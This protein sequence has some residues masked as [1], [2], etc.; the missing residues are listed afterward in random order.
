MKNKP[1]TNTHISTTTQIDAKA[2]SIKLGIDVHADSYRVV[3]QVDHATPQPAQKFSPEGF[4]VWAKRQMGLAEEVHSCYEAGPFGYGLHRALE[5][6]GIHNVVIRP[7]NWDELGKAV[8][9]DKTD[10]LALVQRLDRYVQGN[11]KALAVVCVPTPE[12]EMA[13]SQSRQREQLL[14]HRLRLEAQGRSLLLFNGLRVKGRWWQLRHWSQLKSQASAPLLEL[15]AVIRDLLLAVQDQLH[16]ATTR[17][18]KAAPA[19]VR[20]VGALTSQVLEREILDWHRF[21]NRRQ[22]ASLTGMCPGVHASGS[23]IRNGPI[24][25]HGNRRI[26]TALIELAWRC[27]RFQPNYPPLKRWRSV[28]TSSKASS[29]AKKKAI[30]A[31]G[32]H[33]AIDLW[34]LNTNRATARKLGLQ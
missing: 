6:L 13:R 27:V 32:R 31:V 21:G 3:R 9:T 7:Q 10:A 33:L 24:T 1:N 11:L 12:Q 15:L 8:K 4:L 34:R 19:Q 18:E 20:G 23:R 22:V 28:L 16:A 29:A 30:V 2:K 17:L 26:R 25:K 5:A 14:S